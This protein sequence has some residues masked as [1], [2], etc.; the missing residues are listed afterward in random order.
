MMRLAA[1]VLVAI[2]V[3]F[4]LAV[5]PAPP[6]TWVAVVALVVGGAGVVALSLPMATAGASLALV[7]Y[8]L[9][10][11]IVGAPADPVAAIAFGA[12]LVFLL[13][14]VHFAGCVQGAAIAPSIIT[15]QI[16]RW[17]G[18]VAIGVV[19]AVVLTAAAVAL[20]PTLQ[21]AALPVVIVVA[22]LGALLTVA[23]VVRLLTTATEPPPQ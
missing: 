2:L 11:V 21:P 22:A 15:G 20:G 9:A 16:V 8:G 17:L 14:L 1:G 6:V 19:T 5:L 23:G 13:T 18:I 3:A 4:P 10:L 7:A 12:T